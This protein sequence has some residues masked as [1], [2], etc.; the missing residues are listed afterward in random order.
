MRHELQHIGG[1]S[2][3][4]ASTSG[5]PSAPHSDGTKFVRRG[6]PWQLDQKTRPFSVDTGKSI[7]APVSL[8]TVCSMRT[9]F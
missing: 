4:F 9:T 5:L 1:N 8:A 7:S 2:G 3:A 6:S